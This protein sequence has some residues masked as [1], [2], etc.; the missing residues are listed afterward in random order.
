MHALDEAWANPSSIHQDGQRAR[1]MLEQARTRIATLL[2]CSPKEVVLTSGGT[3]ADNLAILGAVHAD[4]R[5]AR[6]VVTNAVEHPAVLEACA[7]LEREG[8][9]I[10]YLQPDRQGRIDPN[11]FRRQLRPNTV[12]ASVMHANNE[13]GAVH[14]VG[15][16]AAIAREAGILFHSDGV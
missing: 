3:E 16:L 9:A 8:V 5:T 13:T 11:L 15:G 7:Q 2:G 14:D 4:E 1:Q 10:T 12:L 6:H